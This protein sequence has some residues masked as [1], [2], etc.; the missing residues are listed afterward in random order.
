MPIVRSASGSLRYRSLATIL[1]H[2]YKCEE[3]EFLTEIN[4]EY[5]SQENLWD[6]SSVNNRKV[7]QHNKDQEDVVLAPKDYQ[8]DLLRWHHRLGHI[9]FDKIR[10]LEILGALPRLS[11]IHI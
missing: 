11:L 7:N 8:A 9:S 2:Q 5:S 10:L 6:I 1:D 3:K 4:S